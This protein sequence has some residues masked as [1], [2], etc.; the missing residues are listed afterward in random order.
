MIK[1]FEKW[2]DPQSKVSPKCSDTLLNNL[3]PNLSPPLSDLFTVHAKQTSS[4]RNPRGIHLDTASKVHL[5]SVLKEL[6]TSFALK[7]VPPSW[8]NFNLVEFQLEAKQFGQDSRKCWQHDYL[9]YIVKER[10]CR[11]SRYFEWTF[12]FL[13]FKEFHVES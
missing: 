2:S 1:Q 13:Q 11:E 9:C 6:E 7:V 3:Q 5:S 8:S 10:I 12:K 4:F